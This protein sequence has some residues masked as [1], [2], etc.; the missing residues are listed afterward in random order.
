MQQLAAAAVDSLDV[1]LGVEPAEL[2]TLRLLLSSNGVK[3]QTSAQHL[4]I[5]FL[6]GTLL[7]GGRAAPSLQELE[8]DSALQA[9]LLKE[10]A[11][12]AVAVSR[13]PDA[14]INSDLAGNDARCSTCPSR[15]ADL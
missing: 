8:D 15:P 3:D 13:E 14:S 7:A 1:D 4:P 2:P 11:P 5:I 9:A 6:N 12:R 10:L